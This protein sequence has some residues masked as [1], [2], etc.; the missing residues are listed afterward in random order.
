M[1]ALHMGQEQLLTYYRLILQEWK[2]V[3]SYFVFNQIIISATQA[4]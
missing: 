1:P 2:G 4:Y 3:K